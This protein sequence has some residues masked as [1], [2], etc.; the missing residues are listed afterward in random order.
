MD[1]YG[2][3]PLVLNPFVFTTLIS[4]FCSLFDSISCFYFSKFFLHYRFSCKLVYTLSFLVL[5]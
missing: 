1:F 2:I 5:L 3:V 4:I